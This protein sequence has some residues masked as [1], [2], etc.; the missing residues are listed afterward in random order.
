M[1]KL[2]ILGKPE[3]ALLKVDHLFVK[4]H[5]ITAYCFLFVCLFVC[6]VGWLFVW[7]VGCWLVVCL[8]GWLVVCLVG[9]W[10]GGCLL[11]LSSKF[12]QF[13]VQA[14]WVIENI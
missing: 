12:E 6:L 11:L 7:L 4:L 9:W 1:G 8:F 10:V 5:L 14:W 2:S 3:D 13:S